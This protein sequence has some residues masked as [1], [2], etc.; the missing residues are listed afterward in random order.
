MGIQVELPTLRKKRLMSLLETTPTKAG[1]EGA[2]IM[3]HESW[4]WGAFENL[5]IEA[6][7][8]TSHPTRFF[9]SANDDTDAATLA[10]SPDASTKHLISPSTTGSSP[11]SPSSPVSATSPTYRGGCAD[12]FGG[13]V[14]NHRR[15]KKRCGDEK[16]LSP[17]S[18]N[19]EFRPS[20][21]D[22]GRWHGGDDSLEGC[23]SPK[24]NRV[25]KCAAGLTADVAVVCCCPFSLLHLLAIAF[26]KLPAA[27]VSKTAIRIKNKVAERRKRAAVHEEDDDPSPASSCPPS[28][29]RSYDERDTHTWAPALSFGD[30]KLWR[31]YFDSPDTTGVWSDGELRKGNGELLRGKS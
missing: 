21:W 9:N 13:G 24:G 25:C 20:R 17:M 7:P 23:A 8:V 3:D 18:F 5:S 12:P 10:D 15:L 14:N 16:D 4:Q 1:A 2:S 11:L 31:D 29:S 26:I 28:R 27:V 30:Q 19:C 6:G 22:S